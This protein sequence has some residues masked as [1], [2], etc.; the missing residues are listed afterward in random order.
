M[1]KPNRLSNKLAHHP[2]LVPQLVFVALGLAV[3]A[4]IAC[5]T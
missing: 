3:V 2:W 4:F 1:R 5:L